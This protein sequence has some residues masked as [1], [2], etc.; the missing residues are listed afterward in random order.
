MFQ[1]F[2]YRRA[3]ATDNFYAKPLDC[4]VFYDLHADEVTNITVYGPA[5]EQGKALVP[6]RSSNFHRDAPLDFPWRGGIKPLNITQPEGPSFTVRG[7]DVEWQNWSFRV[8]FSWREG[9]IL[10]N[11]GYADE[12]RVRPIIYRAA[13]A[14]IIVPYGDPRSPYDKKCAY[15]ALDYGMA[16]WGLA[17]GRACSGC[18]PVLRVPGSRTDLCRRPCRASA[19]TPW[20]WGATAWGTSSTLTPS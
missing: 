5:A 12:G 14:E 19:P 9:L 1:F 13:L 16:S 15:D 4:V 10:Y 20:S 18:R 7:N 6:S 17:A 2:L 3:F 11:V 8:G